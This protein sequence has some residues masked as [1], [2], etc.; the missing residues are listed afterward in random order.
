MGDRHTDGLNILLE[1]NRIRN[2]ARQMGGDIVLI[3]GNHEELLISYLRDSPIPHHKNEYEDGSVIEANS[4]DAVSVCKK[5][6][7]GLGITELVRFLPITLKDAHKDKYDLLIKK[8]K[9]HKELNGF[10]EK[11]T[12]KSSE[13]LE[14]MRKDPEGRIILETICSFN[15]MTQID[16]NLAQHCPLNEE[17]IYLIQIFGIDTLNSLYQS[18]L[19]RDLLGEK[20]KISKIMKQLFEASRTAF[21]ATENRKYL[22]SEEIDTALTQRGINFIVHGHNPEGG[23][24][25]K[26]G[27]NIFCAN[28]DFGAFY[29]SNGEDPFANCSLAKI[30]AQSGQI[31][32]NNPKKPIIIRRDDKDVTLNFEGI[33]KKVQDLVSS[34]DTQ[35]DLEVRG[36]SPK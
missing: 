10:H 30:E 28:I 15:L 24:V 4:M 9:R 18:V 7:M 19:R 25:Y 5:E 6:N 17:M 32:L 36:K 8:H 2:Q 21:L 26:L 13:I 34:L 23:K 31:S 29:S 20:L 27:D 33:T 3:A 22:Q 35:E 16:D 11:G 12:Y 14:N 1:I